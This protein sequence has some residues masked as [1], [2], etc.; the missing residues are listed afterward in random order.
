MN[1]VMRGTA[2]PV[3]TQYS[4]WAQQ[5]LYQHSTVLYSTKYMGRS[6]IGFTVISCSLSLLKTV[7]G[8]AVWLSLSVNWPGLCVGLHRGLIGE[9]VVGE[10]NRSPGY[11]TSYEYTIPFRLSFLRFCL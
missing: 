4:T 5:G 2:G 8:K 1:S 9:A 6:R 10:D 7:L 3:P 11:T